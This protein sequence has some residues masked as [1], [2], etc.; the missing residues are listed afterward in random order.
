MQ[1]RHDK[2]FIHEVR[3]EFVLQR[4]SRKVESQQEEVSLSGQSHPQVKRGLF[5]P[6][7]MQ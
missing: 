1:I 2:H 4:G 5:C 3:V 7:V 6:N